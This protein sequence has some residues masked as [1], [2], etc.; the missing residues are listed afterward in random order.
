MANAVRNFEA[1]TKRLEDLRIDPSAV[2]TGT[3]ALNNILEK[4]TGMF[5]ALRFPALEG[6]GPVDGLNEAFESAQD[7]IAQKHLTILLKQQ[8]PL[9]KT[10]VSHS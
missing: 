5:D 8:V 7:I 3:N 4:L 10:L 1:S 9:L 2:Q 6:L